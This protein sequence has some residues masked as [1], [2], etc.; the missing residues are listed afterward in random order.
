MG[1]DI[2]DEVGRAGSG[3]RG[4]K[5]AVCRRSDDVRRV[6]DGVARGVSAPGGATQRSYR[7]ALKAFSEEFE[8]VRLAELIA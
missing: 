3:T 8:R 6:R 5:A 4:V 1:R 2:S 7:Y